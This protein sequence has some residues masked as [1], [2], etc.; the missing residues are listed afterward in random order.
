MSRHLREELNVRIR[1]AWPIAS[2]TTSSPPSAVQG[3]RT[4]IDERIARGAQPGASHR[5]APTRHASVPR[6]RRRIATVVTGTVLVMTTLVVSGLVARRFQP[7][8]RPDAVEFADRSAKGL[9]DEP[10]SRIPDDPDAHVRTAITATRREFDDLT[11]TKVERS[12]INFDKRAFADADEF[13]ERTTP[14]VQSWSVEADNGD[15]AFSD[16]WDIPVAS[17]RQ[18][19]RDG[20][21]S[22]ADCAEPVGAM[23]FVD[24]QYYER[25]YGARA[26]ERVI[27]DGRRGPS[28]ILRD[29]IALEGSGFLTRQAAL[30]VLEDYR[31]G[32]TASPGGATGR[33]RYRAAD[34][35][36]ARRLIV[37]LAQGQVIPRANF[38]AGPPVPS[39]AV[40]TVEVWTDDASGLIQRVR[41]EMRSTRDIAE[42]TTL[43]RQDMRFRYEGVPAVAAPE[44]ADDVMFDEWCAR[45]RNARWCE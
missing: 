3:I 35:D 23:R 45:D 39:P 14:F 31:G 21:S 6:R 16:K 8:E 36:E 2:D 1:R 7:Q 15:W 22:F 12:W 30:E 13:A 17:G 43:G 41:T 5:T 11:V 44:Q 26:W 9:A 40:A 34:I 42:D 38:D 32:W 33:I 29:G 28:E 27:A 18:R 20:C 10:P 4:R 19:N 25:A 24:D 37:G